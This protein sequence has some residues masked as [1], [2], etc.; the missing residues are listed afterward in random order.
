MEDAVQAHHRAHW[1]WLLHVGLVLD[2]GDHEGRGG[3]KEQGEQRHQHH[4][5][6]FSRELTSTL[7]WALF[8]CP[9]IGAIFTRKMILGIL[10]FYL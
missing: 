10:I 9:L 5:D 2:V 4:P 8:Y 6:Q 7:V 1:V 3:D